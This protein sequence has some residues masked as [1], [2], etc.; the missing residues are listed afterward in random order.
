MNRLRKLFLR[1]FIIFFYF[2][3][4]KFESPQ[5]PPSITTAENPFSARGAIRRLS[6]RDRSGMTLAR[7]EAQKENATIM[8]SWS[9]EDVGSNDQFVSFLNKHKNYGTF[10]ESISNFPGGPQRAAS[11]NEAGRSNSRDSPNKRV[12]NK[13]S[14]K[15]RAHEEEWFRK[16]ESNARGDFDEDD[17][18][19]NTGGLSRAT[20]GK[21]STRK[22]KQKSDQ[23]GKDKKNYTFYS[24]NRIIQMY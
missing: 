4:K 2:R 21:S 10:Q 3:R 9:K 18:L 17:E 20:R 24:I 19:Q 16:L 1:K 5:Q 14:N 23:I 22:K 11:L 8:R 7:I 12:L 13:N 15:P 6:L